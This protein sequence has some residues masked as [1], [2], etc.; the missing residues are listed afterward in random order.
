MGMNN[1]PDFLVIGAQKCGT[2]ALKRYLD[3]HPDLLSARHETAFFSSNLYNKGFQ[4]Y[5]NQFPIRLR[6]DQLLFEKTPEYIFIPEAPERIF[7]FNPDIKMILLLR[8]PVE[9]AFSGWNHFFRYFSSEKGYEKDRFLQQLNIKY[10]EKGVEG[11]RDFFKRDNYWDFND[12][13]KKEID[14]I[15]NKSNYTGP[16][17]VKRGIYIDQIQRY[18][19]F[20][21][22]DQIL[23]IES[24][25][26]RQN[27]KDNLV[28]IEKFLKLKPFNFD[29]M[30]L[31]E[32]HVSKYNI[33]K[34]YDHNILSRFYKPYNNE[35]FDLL[36]ITYNWS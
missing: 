30:L 33:K 10:G 23:I 36:N 12:Y 27:K 9:R 32:S 3:Q 2:V 29:E 5:K 34:K 6:K 35:L 19:N 20:F 7:R 8:D 22:R 18:L 24:E 31:E 17:F 15:E 26:F 4:Y 11:F 1:L 21:S 28:K 13:I 16:F 25:D 14:L